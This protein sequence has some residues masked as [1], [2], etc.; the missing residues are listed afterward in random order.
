M[1]NN[2]SGADKLNTKDI[3]STNKGTKNQEFYKNEEITKLSKKD[4]SPK[5]KWLFILL[6][7]LIAITISLSISLPIVLTDNPAPSSTTPTNP[8]EP[9]K[10]S[11]ILPLNWT[12]LFKNN[13]NFFYSIKKISFDKEPPKSYINS[14][15]GLTDDIEIWID[16]NNKYNISLVS[17]KIIQFQNGIN[18]SIFTEHSLELYFNNVDTSKMTDMSKMFEHCANIKVIDF[19]SF[20]TSN[21]TSMKNMFKH[22]MAIKQLNL[23]NFETSKVT[24]MSSMFESCD[25]LES[26]YVGEGWQISNNCNT[27]SMFRYCPCNSVT[28]I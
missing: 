5:R 3:P 21:V 10:P 28:K 4:K 2:K 6:A 27:S 1:D 18:F 23:S 7:V 17:E 16:A 12:T 26:I 25:I 9:A 14:G 13:Y 20:D 22:Y 8:T 19:T 15:K 11:T 24:D